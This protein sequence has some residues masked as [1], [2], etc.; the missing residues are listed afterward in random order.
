MQEHQE[1][2]TQ[3]NPRD[4][5]HR[6]NRLADQGIRDALRE[7]AE[8]TS[9]PPELLESA[10]EAYEREQA[11]KKTRWGRFVQQI[12]Q[13]DFATRRIVIS[14]FL[15]LQMQLFNVLGGIF[16][17]QYGLGTISAIVFTAIAIVNVAMTRNGNLGA[18]AGGAFGVASAI[19]LAFF[20]WM[21]H[22]PVLVDGAILIP[23]ALGSAFVGFLLGKYGDRLTMIRFQADPQK[24]RE[25][26]L[27]QLIELQEELKKGEKSVTF[28]SVDVVGSTAMKQNADPLAVEYTFNEYTNY[29]RAIATEFGGA[30][31][32]TAGDGIILTFDQPR[33]A[34]VAARRMQAWM[35]EFNAFRNRIGRPFALRC[36]IH[37]GTVMAE[38]GDASNVNYSHVID[39]CVHTQKVAPVGGIAIT[40]AAAF[41]MPG[42]PGAIGAERAEVQGHR[43]LLWRSHAAIGSASLGTSGDPPPPPPI[44]K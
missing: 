8:K 32:S 35:L 41:Y 9:A 4:S 36:G 12:K 21:F 22:A 17:E 6:V 14:A 3:A 33:Q 13:M 44:Q 20:S 2:E 26:L 25:Y 40:E 18:L 30:L 10:M 28:L 43:V 19:G 1:E 7:I 11:A 39:L 29:I 31:H 16:A 15:G 37:T 24:R 38:K 27:K 34:F 23:W 5:G 42:G